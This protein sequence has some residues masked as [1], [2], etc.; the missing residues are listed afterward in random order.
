MLRSLEQVA[1]EVRELEVDRDDR[2]AADRAQW[3]TSS[4]RAK[5]SRLT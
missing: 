1:L 2:I 4:L 5:D 3:I